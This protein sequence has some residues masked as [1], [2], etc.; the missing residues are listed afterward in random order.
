M[1]T[2]LFAILMLCSVTL[3]L[4][5]AAPED[6][7]QLYTAYNLW[8]EKPNKIMAMNYTVGTMIPAGSKVTFLKTKDG[9][10]PYLQIQTEAGIELTIYMQTK[11]WP[12]VT[13]ETVKDRLLTTKTFDELTK[14]FT[15]E[16]L[17]AIKTGEV[18]TGMSKAAVHVVLGYP[19]TH[20]TPSD[21]TNP[22]MFWRNRFARRAI[23][24]GTDG[25]VSAIR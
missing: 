23:E 9:R 4:A 11:Y 3:G 10:S 15:K 25:K 12:G 19:P 6:G 21:D 17:A 20:M 18:V 22:W 16:E 8:Y 7:G 1:M 5:N 2:K 13:I 14:G 24:F